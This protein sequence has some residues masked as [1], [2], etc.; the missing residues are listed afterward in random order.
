MSPSDSTTAPKASN[1]LQANANVKPFASALITLL[2]EGRALVGALCT[3]CPSVAAKVFRLDIPDSALLPI[4]MFGAREIT[5]GVLTALA[6]RSAAAASSSTAEVVRAE[7]AS[8]RRV[9]LANIATDSL[10]FVSSV[11]ALAS[12][13]VGMDVFGLFGGGALFCVLV[14]TVGVRGL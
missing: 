2:G 7:K 11:V 10:D 1:P 14:G 8:L 12:G 4:A 3:L 13:S 6:N 5:L 9:V